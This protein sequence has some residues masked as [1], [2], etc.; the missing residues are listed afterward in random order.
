M[1]SRL[2]LCLPAAPEQKSVTAADRAA[3][4]LLV[5]EVVAQ[6]PRGHVLL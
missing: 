6:M 2:L 3:T 5:R 4:R 1:M